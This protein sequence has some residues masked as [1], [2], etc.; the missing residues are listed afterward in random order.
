MI[1]C[2]VQVWLEDDDPAAGRKGRSD[3]VETDF[4]DFE[5]F[6]QVVDADR[7]I[8]AS[9]LDTRRGEGKGERIIYRRVPIA[10]RGS[11]VRRA[12]LPTWRIVEE[13]DA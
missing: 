4:V 9:R 3:L 8:C 5:A 6:L 12:E 11:V 2:V 13:A 10:F 7:M 1:R